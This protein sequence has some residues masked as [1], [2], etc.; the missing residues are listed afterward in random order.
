[1]TER[2]VIR[3]EKKLG[4]QL[5]THYR[6]FLL[7]HG[8]VIARAKKGSRHVPFFITAKDFIDANLE[9]RTNP[10]LRDTNGDG[11][12]WPLK[13]LIVGTNGAGDDWCV[14]LTDESEIIW[15]FD[16]EAA[17]TFRPAVPSTWA[18]H[19]K[20][21]QSTPAP[22]R[23][24]IRT[25]RC[26]KG[27]I[28]AD[29]EGDGSFTLKDEKGRDWLCFEQKDPTPEDLLARVQGRFRMP[30]WL[31]NKGVRCLTVADLDHLRECLS[32]ER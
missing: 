30:P 12:P 26:V 31:G 5:P 14:D 13:Y 6:R 10:C 2:D 8:R 29:A 4:I 18:E 17:G 7:E 19:L 25:F 21:L 22:E 15:F 3:V 1:M 23:R 11:Q 28:T 27:V 20:Q 9:L 32:K 16:S 24:L